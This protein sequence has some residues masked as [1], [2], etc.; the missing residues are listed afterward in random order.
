MTRRSLQ[1]DELAQRIVALP[2]P[3]LLGFDVDG[4]LLVD[5]PG[6]RVQEITFPGL[7]RSR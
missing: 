6:A 3:R 2:A 4:T 5:V 1:T 7:R